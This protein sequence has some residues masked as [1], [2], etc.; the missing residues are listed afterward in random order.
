MEE[1]ITELEE[2]L[3]NFSFMGFSEKKL[4][5]RVGKAGR[6]HLNKEIIPLLPTGVGERYRQ[7]I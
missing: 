7:S 5:V 1:Y 6:N 4:G 2:I 3:V